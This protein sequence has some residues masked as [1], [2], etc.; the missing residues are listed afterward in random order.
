MMIGNARVIEDLYYFEDNKTESKQAHGFIGSVCL[1]L[2]HDQIILWHNRL[3]HPCFPYLK[4]VFQIYLKN[5]I[6]IL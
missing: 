5:W 1:S 6:V 2:M 3:G 4:Y